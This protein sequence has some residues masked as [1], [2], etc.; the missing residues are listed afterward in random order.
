[1]SVAVSLGVGVLFCGTRLG[2]LAS[3]LETDA[4]QDRPEEQ[5][6]GDERQ[7]QARDRLGQ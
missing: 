5:V 6:N 4:E 1:M 7:S 2:D 3:A